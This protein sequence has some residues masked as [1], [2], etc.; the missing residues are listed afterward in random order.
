MSTKTINDNTTSNNEPVKLEVISL[1]LARTASL[2]LSQALKI[3]GYNPVYHSVEA[4]FTR[5]KDGT[6]WLSLIRKKFTHHQPI[7]RADLDRA[8]H[9][10]QAA[11]SAPYWAFWRELMLAYPDAKI[12]LVER[13]YEAWMPSFIPIVENFIYSWRGWVLYRIVQPLLGRCDVALMREN[14]VGYFDASTLR[15]IRRNARRVHGEHHEGIRALARSQGREVLEWRLGDGWEGLC[16]FLGKGVPEGVAFPRG[17]ERGVLV[18]GIKKNARR[19]IWQALGVVGRWVGDIHHNSVCEQE[20][21][22]G[23]S[24]YKENSPRKLSVKGRTIGLLCTEAKTGDRLVV[25]SRRP[26]RSF[27]LVLRPNHGDHYD[28]VGQG[29]FINAGE[30]SVD[31]DAMTTAKSYRKCVT[32]TVSLNAGDKVALVGQDVTN[33]SAKYDVE[34]YFQRLIT[35]PAVDPTC[36][37][38]ITF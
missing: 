20:V 1:G 26:W 10:I 5:P 13:E 34:A 4:T 12:I 23:K 22:K 19:Q 28:F 33:K 37:A 14:M 2:S 24:F 25:C 18:E 11:T 27:M 9:G 35:R 38:Q 21:M 32:L 31:W 15:D 8:T 16:G 3:L 6:L 29:I 30:S 7:T 36:A 17:N